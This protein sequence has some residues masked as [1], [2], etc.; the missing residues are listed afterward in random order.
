LIASVWNASAQRE[1]NVLKRWPQ[2]RWE[3][4][5]QA[6]AEVVCALEDVRE[7]Y[8][9]PYAPQRPQVGV[10]ETRTPLVAETRPPIPATP[11]Q[12]ERV[13]YAE[14]RQGT[15][16]LFSVLEPL[17]G[18]RRVQVTERRTAVDFAPLRREVSAEHYRQAEQM[19]L[20]RDQ[21]F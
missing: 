13:D 14:E 1:K 15:A 10:D 19:T 6:N 2:K 11:G 9:R 8:T 16:N 7:I 21:Q 3:I 4:P 20:V 17:A 5:P 12:P 18:Q